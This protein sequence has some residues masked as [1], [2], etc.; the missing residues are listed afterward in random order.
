[1]NRT[2]LPDEMEERGIALLAEFRTILNNIM[3]GEPLHDYQL[4][5]VLLWNEGPTFDLHGD[6]ATVYIGP[7][8]M[9]YEPTFFANL[10]HE[11]A[12]LHVSDGTR[13]NASGLEEGFATYF[14]LFMIQAQYGNDE[15][16]HFERH[17]P[18]NY[19]ICLQDYQLLLNAYPKA[20][21]S[22]RNSFDKLTGPT[23]FQLHSLFPTMS[24]RTCYRLARRKKMR[25]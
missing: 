19:L 17:L 3:M 20:V 23:C 4:K 24:W 12:H 6:D 25:P 8:A 21:E 10:A 14:E 18:Q 11:A 2:S 5:G 13:G 16:T 15:R 7:N 9:Q 1:M 22:V